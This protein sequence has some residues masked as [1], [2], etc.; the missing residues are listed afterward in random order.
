MEP[1]KEGFEKATLSLDLWELTE[2]NAQNAVEMRVFAT[3]GSAI[4]VKDFALPELQNVKFSRR[5][6]PDSKRDFWEGRCSKGTAAD[7][8]PKSLKFWPPREA[9]RPLYFGRSS[10]GHKLVGCRF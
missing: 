3:P 6:A 7:L 4:F 10:H 2:R 9:R 8:D 5:S 1:P